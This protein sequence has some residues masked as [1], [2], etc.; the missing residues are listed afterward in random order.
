MKKFL[1]LILFFIPSFTFGAIT[2]DISS[3]QSS[4]YLNSNTIT[5]T[6]WGTGYLRF[7]NA[8]GSVCDQTNR[9]Y[10]DTEG[11]TTYQTGTSFDYWF[12]GGGE[13]CSPSF[14]DL[15]T[16]GDYTVEAY[17]DDTFTTLLDTGT[18]CQGSGCSIPPSPTPTSTSPTTTEQILLEIHY[19]FLWLLWFIVFACSFIWFE[20]YYKS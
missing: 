20:R 1:I 11:Y 4:G 16:D 8:D 6:G 12:N 9:A 18:F 5:P 17:T 3:P 2:W 14:P 15:T 10:D 13:T 19:D 7:I